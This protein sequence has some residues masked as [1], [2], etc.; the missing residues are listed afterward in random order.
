MQEIKMQVVRAVTVPPTGPGQVEFFFEQR[1]EGERFLRAVQLEGN[2]E[3]LRIES[4]TV[5]ST[6]VHSHKT[7][8]K[9]GR[10]LWPKAMGVWVVLRNES[11]RW[12]ETRIVLIE[13]VDT[14]EVA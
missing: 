12:V 4:V 8:Q 5:G 6:V 10:H 2:T 1:Q 3:H 11:S 7:G 13:S 9:L 14:K